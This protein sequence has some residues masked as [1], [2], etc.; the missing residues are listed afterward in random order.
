MQSIK[1][2]L[3]FLIAFLSCAIFSFGQETVDTVQYEM[4]D[5][6]LADQ[7][8]EEGKKLI[9]ER[10]LNEA[11][12]KLNMSKEIYSQT[13]GL[14]SDK[15]SFVL[16]Q[17]GS[18]YIKSGEFEKAMLYYDKTLEIT[19]E[20]HGAKSKKTAVV[21]NN[22]GYVYS[23]V[24]NY[25]KALEFFEKALEINLAIS[26]EGD[27]DVASNYNSIGG[28]YNKL[29]KYESAITSLEKSLQI[30]MELLHE[31][32]YLIGLTH[33]KLG[34]SYQDLGEYEKA[35]EYYKKA[36]KIM[37][38][39]LGENHYN[40]VAIY[41][42]LGSTLKAIG[43][44]QEAID[45]FNIVKDRLPAFIGENHPAL[46]IPYNNIGNA[47][48]EIGEYDLALV[49]HKIA[50]KIRSK[51]LKYPHVGLAESYNNLGVV[52]DKYGKFKQA[53]INH[54][55]ALKIRKL[56]LGEEHFSVAQ[57]YYNI[58]ISY[59]NFGEYEKS[60]S[61]LQKSLNLRQK[62]FGDKHPDV[63]HSYNSIGSN[64]SHLGQPELSLK[65]NTKALEV[66]QNTYNE[67][68]SNVAVGLNSIGA[69]YFDSGDFRK[70][71]EY[72]N[73]ALAIRIAVFDSIHPDIAESLVNLGKAYI[74]EKDYDTAVDFLDKA[75]FIRQNIFG[76]M[77]PLSANIFLE[78]AKISCKLNRPDDAVYLFQKALESYKYGGIDELNEVNSLAGLLKALHEQGVFYCNLYISDQSFPYLVKAHA[79]FKEALYVLDQQYKI[80]SSTSFSDLTQQA[81]SIYETSLLSNH[82]LFQE[83]D[84]LFY[85]KESFF[86][87]ERSKSL[88]L[89]Q[90]I[91]ETDALQYANIPD[92]LLQ[93]EYDLRIDITY[94]DKKRQE[95]LSEGLEETDTTVLAISSKLFDL[96]EEYEA[97]KSRFEKDY[98]DYYRLKYDLST[99]SLEYVQDTLLTIDQTLLEYFVGDSSIFIFTVSREQYDV[100]EVKKDFPLEDW[101]K[102]LQNGLTGYYTQPLA[103]RTDDLYKATIKQYMEAG[104]QLYRKLIA[105]VKEKLNTSEL[106]IVPDGVLG[107][108]PFGALLTDQ[109]K[110][111][112]IFDTY[113][114]LEKDYKISYCYSATL[115]REMKGKQ[116]K[117]QP[118][119]SLVAFAPFYEG[120]YTK[121]DSTFSISF[122]TLANGQDTLIFND[123]ATRKDFNNLP[124]SGEE[125]KAASLF[126]DGDYYLNSDATEDRFNEV[127][128]NYRIVHLSTHG[129]ADSR[130]G[131]YSYL[132]FAEQKDSIE[133]ELLYV[134]DLYNIQLNA[135]LVTLSACETAAGE[136]QRGEGIISLARAFAYAGAKSIVT[137]LWVADDA[138]TKDL[139]KVFYQYLKNGDPKDEA[140]Q[141]AKLRLQESG[142]FAHPFFWAGFVPVGDMSSLK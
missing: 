142:N 112:G 127:V 36:L 40:V 60:I 88:L 55:E 130:S 51:V 76:K 50:L 100:V 108:V 35:I 7:L 82:L 17:L 72:F 140:L 122:D 105:P 110:R 73:K 102:Q 5:T 135:D 26:G 15:L 80:F 86:L 97:L 90:S 94:Y 124:A 19:I 27:L 103:K 9:E 6:V 107:Y 74:E 62:I 96:N 121:L 85:Q 31:D 113:P 1:C 139:M 2:R 39:S 16:N 13:L 92:S 44:Y 30:K 43:K 106:I 64:Y 4:K 52:Y 131:D 21:L 34:N 137:T 20:N 77:H 10:K 120:S 136:L 49:N 38:D 104:Q 53:L 46:A 101:V 125:V 18:A 61:Y 58:G 42:S 109:P 8:L 66:F 65:Y 68:H 28:I 48:I 119:G 69:S 116:H 134:R 45:Y 91:Q 126:W 70:S 98:P 59:F 141:T 25:E 54:E 79:I 33:I 81:H 123:I 63:A 133:N 138:A 22:I 57:S 67:P 47:Y 41:N 115:L 132:A 37:I 114:F 78:K 118:K 14:H 99:V 3:S 56:V 95:K 32:D 84:S 23:D 129:V 111:A 75:L 93:K 29:G 117:Q 89:Y 71:V 24:K 83:T 12:E 128:G 87:A 11:L